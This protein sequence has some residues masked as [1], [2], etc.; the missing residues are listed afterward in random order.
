MTGAEQM[1]FPSLLFDRD[2]RVLYVAEV[3]A[4]L[5]ISVDHVADLIAE[6]ALQAVDVGGGGRKFWRIPIESYHAFLKN[7]H[8]HKR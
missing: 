1:E 3:A 8:S 7:R 2:R 5:S 6:G 4:R